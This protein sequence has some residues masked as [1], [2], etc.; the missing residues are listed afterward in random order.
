MNSYSRCAFWLIAFLSAACDSD[1]SHMLPAGDAAVLDSA[2]EGGLSATTN[3]FEHLAAEHC[4]WRARCAISGTGACTSTDEV[5]VAL[6]SFVSVGVFQSSRVQNVATCFHD[7]TLCEGD[8]NSTASC[9]QASAP[10]DTIVSDCFDRE[11]CA[12]R[13]LGGDWC[14]VVPLLD[15]A[16]RESLRSC[17]AMSDCA[18]AAACVSALML[19]R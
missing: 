12:M 17:I 2:P 16:T 3:D 19:L 13:P 9:V 15:D 14:T 4:A 1:S 7:L 10:T 11:S 5:D 8:E 6:E 18:S